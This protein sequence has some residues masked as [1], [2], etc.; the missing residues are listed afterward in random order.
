MFPSEAKQK[1]GATHYA[2]MRDGVTPQM[3]Y[4]LET[5]PLSG[6][7]S[8]T[9]WVYLSF[10]D[11]WMGSSIEI[12]SSEESNLKEIIPAQLDNDRETSHV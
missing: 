12:G 8:F 2:V 9:C 10:A 5:T 7:C 6:G 1:Y 11:I 4:K 3:Y